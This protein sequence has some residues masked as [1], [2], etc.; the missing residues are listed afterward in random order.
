MSCSKCRRT[1]SAKLLHIS[2]LP[3][4]L[5][6]NVA[7][8]LAKPSRALFAVT[9]TAPTE[10]WQKI[11]QEQWHWQPSTTIKAIIA[12]PSLTLDNNQHYHGEDADG[13]WE[14]QFWEHLDFVDVEKNLANNLTDADIHAV[15]VYI[16][17]K[18]KLKSLKLTGC[19]KTSGEGWEPLWGSS[20]LEQIDMS[21]LKKHEKTNVLMEILLLLKM[22]SRLSLIALLAL[23]VVAHWSILRSHKTGTKLFLTLDLHHSIYWEEDM[24]DIYKALVSTVSSVMQA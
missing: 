10:S 12:S 17:A 14:D 6:V 2:A 22:L 24:G 11:K 21:L 19:I 20:V 23:V 9:M 4:A 18:Q 7:N 8:F 5:L 1:A 13:V 15:L 16:N 3:D